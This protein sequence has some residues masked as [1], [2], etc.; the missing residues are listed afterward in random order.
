MI[1]NG[2]RLELPKDE[3][4]ANYA[5]VKKILI[6]AGGEYKKSGFDFPG[7]AAD[8]QN[9]LTGGEVIDDKK[10]YQFF[11]T[12]YELAKELVRMADISPGHTCLEPSAGQGAISDLILKEAGSC[13]VIELMPDNIKILREKGWLPIEGDFLKHEPESLGLFDRIVANPPFTKNQ[14]IDHIRHMYSMLKPGGKLVSVASKSWTHGSQKKQVSFR[15]WLDQVGA[16]VSEV[17][18]GTFK[19]SGTSV[20][21]VIIEINRP[22]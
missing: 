7:S 17:P 3:Q 11:A 10:K 16:T 14:D 19:A 12:P 5:Q 9:R 20:G 22:L 6:K 4:L 15:V 13:T 18:A 21:A 1:A 2:K 8:I